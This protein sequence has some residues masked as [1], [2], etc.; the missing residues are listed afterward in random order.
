[1]Q[2]CSYEHNRYKD[3]I[4]EEDNLSSELRA[5]ISTDNAASKLML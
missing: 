2:A 3:C 4:Y 1:M 5:I